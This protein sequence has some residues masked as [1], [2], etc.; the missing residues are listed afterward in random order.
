M[1]RGTRSRAVPGFGA[2]RVDGERSLPN[3]L[4]AQLEERTEQLALING[5]LRT[6]VAGA[7]LPHILKVFASNLKTICPFDRC[8]ISL[9]D[10]RR[11]IFKVPYMVMGGKVVETR[12]RPRPFASSPLSRVVTTRRPM[13]RRNVRA[14][15]KTYEI[16][17]AFLAKGYACEMLLPL[18][19]GDEVLGTFN[20][21]TW[22]AD[23][24]S[25]DHLRLL[26]DVVPAIAVAVWSHRR[27]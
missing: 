12:E 23:R 22:E 8:S 6:I 3:R 18:Q 19:V 2:S 24:F 21:G 26:Q 14:E 20:L 5:V 15:R 9:Y 16:D 1:G 27:R 10:A 25:G 7:A 13:L 11:K 4:L 17:R